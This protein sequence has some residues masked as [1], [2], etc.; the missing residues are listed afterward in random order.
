MLLLCLIF[1]RAAE[2]STDKRLI[3]E[4]LLLVAKC[5]QVIGR[6]DTTELE[7]LNN[8]VRFDPKK[9]RRLFNAI[10]IL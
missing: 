9:T 6:R 4:Y 2:L 3:Y 10:V 1:L 7:L 8:A 5:I